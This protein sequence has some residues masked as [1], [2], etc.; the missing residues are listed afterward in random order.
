[1]V[2]A[3]R[4]VIAER[5]RREEVP[6]RI[7]NHREEENEEEN[8]EVNQGRATQHKVKYTTVRKSSYSKAH[9]SPH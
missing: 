1:M 8:Q 2:C 6:Q 9:E 5:G 4:I 7:E 3:R